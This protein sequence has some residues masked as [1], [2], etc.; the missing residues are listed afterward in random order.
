MSR[1]FAFVCTVSS[2]S[3]LFSGTGFTETADTET[4]LPLEQNQTSTKVSAPFHSFTGKVI[5][6]KVRMRAQPGLE[7]AIVRELNKGDLFL[8]IDEVEDF[9]AVTPPEGTKAFVFRTFVLDGIVE[10]SHVNVRLEPNVE[11]P[12]IAQLNSGDRIEGKICAGNN[13]WLEIVPPVSSKLYIAKEFVQNIGNAELIT[14][15]KRRHAEVVALVKVSR[16]MSEKEFF[17][18]FEEM[19]LSVIYKNLNKAIQEYT[20]F[21]E[22][23][24]QA[25]QLLSNIEAAFLQK[26]IAYLE[27]KPKIVETIQ[28]AE[29]K[30]APSI[31]TARVTVWH[32]IEDA[33]YNEWALSKKDGKIS[34]EEFYQEQKEKSITLTGTIDN[35]MRPVKNRPGDYVLVNGSNHL[36]LAFIYSTDI[37]LQDYV[38]KEVTIDAAERPNN[39]FA[40]PA[41]FVLSVD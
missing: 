22:E 17:N 35:Y 9:Y 7:G 34:R 26:K 37:N 20:D 6:N 32:P 15:L 41:Y 21:P 39:N 11:A 4:R 23:A 12:V 1:G 36:P 29:T 38:G 33:I 30:N 18:S 14:T 13:K 24:A 16:E 27:A 28:V 19:N 3:F 40:F 31:H 8:V 2:L 25:K 5:K 10:G